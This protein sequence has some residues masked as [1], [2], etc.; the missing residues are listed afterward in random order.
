MPWF[1]CVRSIGHSCAFSSKR[2]AA[3]SSK[4]NVESSAS[5][6]VTKRRPAA[7]DADDH[8]SWRSGSN[9]DSPWLVRN[10]SAHVG[11]G[12]LRDGGV[13]GCSELA[14]AQR[15]G[16][17]RE[18]IAT[19]ELA[20]R[21]DALLRSTLGRLGNARSVNVEANAFAAVL[22]GCLMEQSAVTAA[23]V[24]QYVIRTKP[25]ACAAPCRYVRRGARHKW[26]DGARTD[27]RPRI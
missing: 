21:R 24:P 22:H 5:T 20:Q 4:S 11:G 13:G 25:R 14:S 12:E 6:Q 17:E 19:G 18:Q 27:G 15:A 2:P 8:S 26:C 23:E 7:S 1:S 3:P 9:R 10:I 16:L